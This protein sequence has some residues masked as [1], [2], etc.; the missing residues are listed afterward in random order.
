MNFSKKNYSLSRPFGKLK[1]INRHSVCNSIFSIVFTIV[2]ISSGYSQNTCSMYYPFEEGTAFQITGYDKKGKTNSVMDYSITDVTGNTATINTKISDKKG[3]EIT[4]TDY[5]I[6]CENNVISIDFKSLMNPDMFAQYKDME[7]DFEGT[8]IELPDDLSVGKNLKDANMVMTIKMGGLNM[9][10]TMD[11]VNRKVEGKESIT[12]P[13]GT[14]DCYVITYTME[15]KMGMK[16]TIKNKE[17]I[18][19]GVGMV[20]S[21][22]YNKNGKLMGYSELTNISN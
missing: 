14:F 21:E 17:W 1:N 15:M 22:N 3:E 11:L 2:C 5:K 20:K 4:T 10:M 12:T 19:E 13:A 7:V 6:T 9:N 16:S 18:A 8:N